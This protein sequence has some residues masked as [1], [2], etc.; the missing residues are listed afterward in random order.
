MQTSTTSSNAAGRGGP[1]R[2][3]LM[4]NWG[5]GLEVLKALD[6][7]PRVEASQVVTRCAGPSDDPWALAVRE[8]AEKLGVPVACEEGL[9][10]EAVRGLIEAVQA[11][12]LV[13]H[14]Y[15]RRLPPEVF[16]TP[17]LGGINIH[18][19]LLPRHRGPSPTDWVLRN[20]E[21]ETGLTAHYIDQGLDTG[22]IVHQCRIPVHAADDRA[23]VIE[24]L[25]GVVPELVSATIQKVLAPEFRP[26]PQT[27]ES[28][29]AP[30]PER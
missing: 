3:V 24:R 30:R 4:A 20:K 26:R 8:G 12:L 9:S 14:A 7:D 23:S 17:R 2:V 13:V 5:L 18:A 6:A 29:F 21:R 11:D 19:S 25:K 1:I 27:G 10:F 16:K 28:S 22:D 15:P